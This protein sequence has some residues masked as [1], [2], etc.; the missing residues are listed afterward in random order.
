MDPMYAAQIEGS[1]PAGPAG[2]VG[3]APA[4]LEAVPTTPV[5]KQDGRRLRSER[6]RAAIVAALEGLIEE[7]DLK[8]TAPR[9]ALRASVS[10]RTVFQHFADIEL[11][12]AA[13]TAKQVREIAAEVRLADPSLPL[14]DRLSAYV[15]QRARLLEKITPIARAVTMR[16]SYSP[17]VRAQAD[18]LRAL[19]RWE[20]ANT[21]APELDRLPADQRAR[22]V[23]ALRAC[24]TWRMWEIL[25]A[26]QRFD[27]A[28][29]E[30][31]I[32]LQMAAVLGLG[33]ES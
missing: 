10:L 21:F 27:A 31:L 5:V 26:E 8:P 25:R 28:M 29:A 14:P 32:T 1:A 18:R 33:G 20:V 19:A 2:A 17:R 15:S 13:M 9:I 11:L 30:E 6:T 4:P 12:F 3:L 7:G 22:R 16:E 23:A 24:S